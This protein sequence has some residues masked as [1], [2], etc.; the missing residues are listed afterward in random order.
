MCLETKLFSQ[1]KKTL[2][3][4]GAGLQIG[5]QKTCTIIAMQ[6]YINETK[7][8]PRNYMCTKHQHTCLG[9]HTQTRDGKNL[10]LHWNKWKYM[11]G[12]RTGVSECVWA[13][14]FWSNPIT[15]RAR[16]WSCTLIHWVFIS[17]VL[18]PVWYQPTFRKQ[19]RLETAS[20]WSDCLLPKISISVSDLYWP[21]WPQSF[22]N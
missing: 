1:L 22:K 14:D 16:N 13:G 3:S 20:F 8:I 11:T 6:A 18:L 12:Y 4:T 9:I 7:Q 2:Y 5:R 10:I 17:F 21:G 19:V 15:D